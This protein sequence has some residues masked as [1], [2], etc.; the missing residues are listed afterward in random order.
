MEFGRS[1]D[2]RSYIAWTSFVLF[3]F[4]PTVAASVVFDD[5]VNSGDTTMINDLPMTVSYNERQSSAVLNSS[6]GR[7]VLEVGECKE[8]GSYRYCFLTFDDSER[9]V[10]RSG[11]EYPALQIRV[12]EL[13]PELKI[14]RSISSSTIDLGDRAE[15]MVTIENRGDKPAFGIVYE[16]RMPQGIVVIQA[17]GAQRYPQF[18]R[19]EGTLSPHKTV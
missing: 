4:L 3:L 12:E 18:V 15:I 6:L 10:Y 1:R 9:V 16:D 19:W 11:V 8:S 7:W 14:T 2:V 13:A 17:S 5:W